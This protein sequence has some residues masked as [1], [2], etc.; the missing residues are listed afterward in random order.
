MER[1]APRLEWRKWP[2]REGGA[3]GWIRAGLVLALLSVIWLV[4]AFSLPLLVAVVLALALF[5]AVLPFFTPHFY[6][7]DARGI[8]IRQGIIIWSRHYPWKKFA[9]CQIAQDG[10]WLLPLETAP[11]L[12]ALYLPQPANETVSTTL[13]LLLEEHFPLF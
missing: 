8:T 7:I 4:L 11:T 2:L 3:K 5:L 6:R 12:Q 9:G 10:Y 13:R 1:T